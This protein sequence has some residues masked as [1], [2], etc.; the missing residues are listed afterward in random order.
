MKQHTKT[1][2]AFIAEYASRDTKWAVEFAKRLLESKNEDDEVSGGNIFFDGCSCE[3]MNDDCCDKK[4]CEP[5]EGRVN[6]T[7]CMKK[8]IEKK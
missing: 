3:N 1:C 8:K 5:C 4:T 6:F 7:Y 2:I